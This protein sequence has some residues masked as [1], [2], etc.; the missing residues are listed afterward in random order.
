MAKDS[1][2]RWEQRTK[3][4]VWKRLRLRMNEGAAAIFAKREDVKLRKVAKS[5]RPVRAWLVA[6]KGYLGG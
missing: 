6:R 2:Y 5:R 4:G 3:R 1:I